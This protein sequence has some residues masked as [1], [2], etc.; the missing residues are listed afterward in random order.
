ML[1]ASKFFWFLMKNSILKIFGSV[2]VKITPDFCG[3][4]QIFGSII[5]DLPNVVVFG[6]S[7]ALLFSSLSTSILQ[8]SICK[9]MQ[10]SSI[11][12]H[13]YTLFFKSILKY[14]QT[15]V[16][17]YICITLNV[18]E[19]IFFVQK[20]EKKKDFEENYI[21][22]LQLLKWGHTQTYRYN[23]TLKNPI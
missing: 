18:I 6:L 4:F 9:A 14:V 22:Q 3:F 1:K 19:S 12:I 20:N 17:L 2:D 11:A 7:T 15:I 23:R 21:C 16:T 8:S 13:W 5:T 10:S